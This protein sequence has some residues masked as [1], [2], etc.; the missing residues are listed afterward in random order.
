MMWHPNFQYEI[1]REHVEN[2]RRQAAY[3]RLIHRLQQAHPG[4]LQQTLGGMLT[5][6]GRLLMR[7][8]EGLV[9]PGGISST[10]SDVAPHR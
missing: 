5:Q 3:E 10:P 8:G 9:E 2:R 7:L 4:R 1:V 6:S